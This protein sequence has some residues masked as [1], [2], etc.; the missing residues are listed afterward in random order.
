MLVMILTAFKPGAKRF[1][2]AESTFAFVVWA[3]SVTVSHPPIQ[4]DNKIAGK[5]KCRFTASYRLN[6]DRA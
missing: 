6:R 3:E 5:A 1:C 2:D 4:I